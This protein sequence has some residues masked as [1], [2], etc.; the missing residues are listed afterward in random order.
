MLR[1]QIGVTGS[2]CASSNL[3]FAELTGVRIPV[4]QAPMAAV[5]TPT[6]Y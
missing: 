3:T 4:V 6:G 1:P 5:L 2:W